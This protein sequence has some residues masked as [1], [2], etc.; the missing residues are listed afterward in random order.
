MNNALNE[1]A[2]RPDGRNSPQPSEAPVYISTRHQ[3]TCGRIPLTSS[4][5]VGVAGERAEQKLLSPHQ[6]AIWPIPTSE[7][8]YGILPVTMLHHECV[9]PAL[10][11]LFPTYLYNSIVIGI[12]QKDRQ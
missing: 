9:L 5:P 10:L 4:D 7:S 3:A 11:A 12:I 1:M 2:C 6:K 8:S